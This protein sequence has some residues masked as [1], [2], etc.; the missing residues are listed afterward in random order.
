MVGN[1]ISETFYTY[2]VPSTKLPHT[3]DAAQHSNSTGHHQDN[4]TK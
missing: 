3:Y 4:M 1:S 2:G